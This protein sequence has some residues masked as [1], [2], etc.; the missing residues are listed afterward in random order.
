[1]LHIISQNNT[2]E[3]K[4]FLK[5][6]IIING[7]KALIKENANI[8]IKNRFKEAFN[9]ILHTQNLLINKLKIQYSE[10]KQLLLQYYKNLYVNKTIIDIKQ[11]NV[12]FN[13]LDLL[14]ISPIYNYII[15]SNNIFP[16]LKN[17]IADNDYKHTNTYELLNKIFINYKKIDKDSYLLNYDNIFSNINIP[18]YSNNNYIPNIDNIKNHDEYIYL[19]F[20][21]L[22]KYYML[23]IYK[24]TP[25]INQYYNYFNMNITDINNY[26]IFN[27]KLLSYEQSL[28]ITNKRY[29][30]HPFSTLNYKLNK[31]SKFKYFISN[32]NKYYDI[33]GIKHNFNLYAIKE[34]NKIKIYNHNE[35]IELLN[36][37][38]LHEIKIEYKICSICKQLDTD[39]SNSTK[40]NI[41][42]NNEIISE[43]NI[44]KTKINSFFNYFLFKCPKKIYHSFKLDKCIHCNITKALLLNKDKNYYDEYK[45]KFD[46]ILVK[47]INNKNKQLLNIQKITHNNNNKINS[48]ILEKNLNLNDKYLNNISELNLSDI[49]KLSSLL[50]INKNYL[51]YLGLIEK[52]NYNEIDL[53]KIIKTDDNALDNRYFKL[54]NYIKYLIVMYNIFKKSSKIL[55]FDNYEFYLLLENFKKNGL[56]LNKLNKLPQF[57]NNIIDLIN[58][59]KLNY[60]NDKLNIILLNL[61]YSHLIFILDNS[62]KISNE[63][64]KVATEFIKFILKNILH[65]DELTSNFDYEKIQT[66]LYKKDK[67]G[68]VSEEVEDTTKLPDMENDDYSN[69]NDNTPEDD[70]LQD[71]FTYDGFDFDEED[72][73]NL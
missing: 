31:I 62:K 36:N 52:K 49:D 53:I 34:N 47:K 42:K 24:Y 58:Y 2:I 50:N 64:N 70:D 19:S 26:N 11:D 69:E 16:L 9:L 39:I 4:P 12:Q 59:Y 28:T 72:E 66:V 51:I 46:S 7:G 55:K 60:T 56:D 63:I 41:I 45:H 68:N 40:D 10:I 33:D 22:C 14:K 13:I 67:K 37:K 25:F 23:N 1:M 21:S 65:Y 15:R 71:I 32:F 6:Q 61:L 8:F 54:F 17:K 30:L 57:N 35:L 73:D 18:E 48:S 38:N 3:F 29:K 27:D 20:I 44:D 5:K 43:K